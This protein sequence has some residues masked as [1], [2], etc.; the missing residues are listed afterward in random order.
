[1]ANTTEGR[2][3]EVLIVEDN[4]P[5][6]TLARESFREAQH[7]VR[8]HHVSNGVECMEFLY[9]RGKY[10][11]A[12]TPDLILLDLNMPVM[13]GREV[14]AELVKDDE[15]NHLPVVILTTSNKDRDVLDMYK[16]RCSSYVRKPVDYEQFIRAIRVITD[17]WFT[18]VILPR[19]EE[20]GRA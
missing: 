1:M 2:V 11:D 15:L 20:E 14:L 5:D 16:L 12:P 19:W 7:P 4:E 13:D 3:A 18:V 17:Y 10:I 9:K 6:V 8:L